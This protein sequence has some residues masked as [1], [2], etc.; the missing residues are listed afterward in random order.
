MYC[1][2]HFESALVAWPPSSS[3]SAGCGSISRQFMEARIAGC[4]MATCR[5]PANDW[6]AVALHSMLAPTVLTVTKS[7]TV[8]IGLKR[9]LT[10]SER[11]H[12][13][14][15]EKLVSNN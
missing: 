6:A 3:S 5:L 4:P 2:C 14:C 12:V 10:R 9:T 8:K 7:E 1:I 13:W 11:R 15:G